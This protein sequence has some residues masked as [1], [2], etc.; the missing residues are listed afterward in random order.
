MNILILGVEIIAVFSM[1]LLCKKLFGK[2]GVIAWVMLAS[3]LA[4]IIT[5]K[6]A[7][8]AGLN[9]AIGSVLFA[10]TFLATD[11]LTECYGEKDAR[12]AVYMG[13]FGI[14]VFIVSSQIALWYIPSGIDY[15]DGAMRVLF[16]MNLRI[17]ISSA[18]MYFAANMADVWLFSKLKKKM[19]GRHLWVRN[20][21]S[22]ILCNCLENFLFMFFAFFG[23]YGLKDV[24]AM[25]LATS[26]IEA[27]VAVCDT[28]F[29][30]LARGIGKSVVE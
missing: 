26:V 9:T 4:N 16:S 22:T 6:N 14:G 20:N 8:I 1:L 29:L 12:K 2:N 7:S 19:N 30:Y 15:A 28:P 5:A 10:S 25:A 13:L 17:S 11:I 27:V 21:V 24:A 3:V 23:I 18:V